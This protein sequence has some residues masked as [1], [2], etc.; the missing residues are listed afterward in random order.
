MRAS[1]TASL[2]WADGLAHMSG[3]AFDAVRPALVRLDPSSWPARDALNA[4]AQE[5]AITNARG[6]PI[7]FVAAGDKDSALQYESRIAERGEIVTREN[8]HDLFNALQWLSFPQVKAVISEQHI[9]NFHQGPVSARPPARDVLT[10]FDENGLIIVSSDTALLTLVREFRWKELFVQRR[11]DLRKSMRFLLT[12][13]GILEKTLQPYVGLTAKALLL[14]LDQ[15]AMQTPAVEIAR[16]ADRLAAAWLADPAHLTSTR[17]LHPLPLLGVPGWD[18][19]NAAEAFYDDT[20]YFRP[21]YT[22]GA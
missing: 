8:W 9:R 6:V 2:V 16:A 4:L 11:A 19:R 22:R 13:H 12:G 20:H 3:P 1:P 18:V 7:R 14:E 15:P 5:N 10:L 17:N 21:G